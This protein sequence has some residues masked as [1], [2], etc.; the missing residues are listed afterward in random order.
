[1][2][3]IPAETLEVCWT[4]SGGACEACTRTLPENYARHHRRAYGQGGREDDD[5][6]QNMPENIL[7]LHHRCHQ[8]VHA[9]PRQSREYGFIVPSWSQ[10]ADVLVLP[11]LQLGRV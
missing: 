4:R 6:V 9:N 3:R 10:P 11:L 8:W 5:P 1:M 7:L 2:S